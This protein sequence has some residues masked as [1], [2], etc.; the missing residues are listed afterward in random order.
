MWSKQW[1]SPLANANLCIHIGEVSGNSFTVKSAH[2]WRVS[3]DGAIRDTFGNLRRVFMMPENYSLNDMPKKMST[4]Q[5]IS[6][7]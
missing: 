7:Q 2:T 6:T 4:I 3:P 1:N 5:N